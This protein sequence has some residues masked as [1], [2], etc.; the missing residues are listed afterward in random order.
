VEKLRE[1]LEALEALPGTLAAEMATA[2][3]LRIAKAGG[4]QDS[5][6]MSKLRG[7]ISR[8]KEVGCPEALA[9]AAK[10]EQLL[11]QLL[12]ARRE[13]KPV[14]TRIRDCEAC[15]Q[16]REGAV[17]KAQEACVAAKDAVQAAL[18]AADKAAQQLDKQKGQLQEARGDLAKLYQQKSSS[19]SEASPKPAQKWEQGVAA[20]QEA[21]KGTEPVP[22]ERIQAILALLANPV[23]DVQDSQRSEDNG[24]LMDTGPEKDPDDA[25]DKPEDPATAPSAGTGAE[26]CGVNPL[27][28]WDLRKS[29]YDGMD[30]EVVATLL[31]LPIADRGSLARI[32]HTIDPDGGNQEGRKSF[33]E[34]V[35][36]QRWTFGPTQVQPKDGRTGPY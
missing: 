20:L 34:I 21:G 19:T 18:E 31:E 3:R 36:K 16:R 11:E 5:S 14:D 2:T 35:A 32:L 10:K 17:A 8:L 13:A 12:K 4:K 23:I 33:M 28:G 7:D 15:V 9:M 26:S 6:E 1:D 30:E 29:D 25:K 27:A 24:T 22:P